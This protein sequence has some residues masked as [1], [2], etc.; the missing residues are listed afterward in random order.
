M[1]ERERIRV[2]KER[3]KEEVRDN[4]EAD[5][6]KEKARGRAAYKHKI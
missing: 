5:R 4:L 6:K 2:E 3:K 1:N